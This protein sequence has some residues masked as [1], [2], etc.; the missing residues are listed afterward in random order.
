MS[1]AL[2]ACRS[3]APAADRRS[4]AGAAIFW[5]NCASYEDCPVLAGLTSHVI[6]GGESMDARGDARLPV[7]ESSASGTGTRKA[8]DNSITPRSAKPIGRLAGRE[9]EPAQPYA[10]AAQ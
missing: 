7:H 3:T 8:S 5:P 1:K 10:P 9:G 6:T 2:C 4:A